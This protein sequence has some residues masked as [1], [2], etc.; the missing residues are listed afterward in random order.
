MKGASEMSINHPN[1]LPNIFRILELF[2]PIVI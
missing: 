2:N 1:I